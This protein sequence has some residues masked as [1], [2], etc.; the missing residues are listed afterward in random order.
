[1]NYIIIIRHP[2]T[3]FEDN[4]LENMRGT[5]DHHESSS[6]IGWTYKKWMKAPL[7]DIFQSIK[8][9]LREKWPCLFLQSQSYIWIP[10]GPLGHQHYHRDIG[11]DHERHKGVEPFLHKLS[12]GRFI[13]QLFIHHLGF[14][15]IQTQW[16][17]MES[18]AL[19]PQIAVGCMIFI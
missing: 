6:Q 17:H 3:M 18:P 11:S 10:P 7:R 19:H 9:L 15:T 8:E 14:K 13:C 12:Q 4:Q 2:H 5:E 1:M 16:N